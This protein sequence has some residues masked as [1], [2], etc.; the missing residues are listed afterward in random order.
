MKDCLIQF[1]ELLCQSPRIELEV[2]LA[3]HIFHCFPAGCLPICNV[4]KC[5]P[6]LHVHGVD[7]VWNVIDQST[8]KISFPLEYIL[9]PLANGNVM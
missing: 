7:T 9:D 3:D 8:Q 6:P 2:R 4:R 5:F 1:P